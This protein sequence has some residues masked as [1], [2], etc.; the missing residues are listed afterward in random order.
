MI[1]YNNRQK[2]RRRRIYVRLVSKRSVSLVSIILVSNDIP[3]PKGDEDT[4][5]ENNIKYHRLPKTTCK[6]FSLA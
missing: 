1:V 4:S 6:L 3:S 2:K 5:G